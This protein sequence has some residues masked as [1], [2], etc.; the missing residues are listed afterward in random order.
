MKMNNM[1]LC[2]DFLPQDGG[3]VCLCVGLSS[4]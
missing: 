3:R 1:F 4:Q 2:E